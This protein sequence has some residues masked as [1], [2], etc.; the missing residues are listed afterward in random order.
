M[1]TA[2]PMTRTVLYLHPDDRLPEAHELMQEFGFH[3]IP[4][5]E[6]Q[7]VVGILSDR[8]ILLYAQPTEDGIAVP[9]LSIREVMTSEVLTCQPDTSMEEI[10]SAMLQYNLHSIPVTDPDG[11][12][13]GLVTASDLLR[14]LSQQSEAKKALSLSFELKGRHDLSLDKD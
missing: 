12:L 3:H 13:H 11:N 4:L 6:G 10:A 2:Q 8:D 14:T 9:D 5:L 7:K 1:S